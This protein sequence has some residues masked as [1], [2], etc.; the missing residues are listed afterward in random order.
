MVSISLLVI[1]LEKIP[2]DDEYMDVAKMLP[3]LNGK[4]FAE[5]IRPQ[6]QV[7]HITIFEEAKDKEIN[8][9]MDS[10]RKSLCLLRNIK[11]VH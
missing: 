5:T 4:I 10:L 2:I 1:S 7:K 8:N 11:L 6:Q 9:N 3:P